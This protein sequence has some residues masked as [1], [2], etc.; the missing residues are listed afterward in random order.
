MSK[1]SVNYGDV[2]AFDY[3]IKHRLGQDFVQVIIILSG[4]TWQW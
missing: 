4:L 3:M 1:K 2:G